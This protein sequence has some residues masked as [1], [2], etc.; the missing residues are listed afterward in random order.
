MAYIG[1]KLSPWFQSDPVNTF[2]KSAALT[3]AKEGREI[4]EKNT[5]VDTGDL[6]AAWQ[7]DVRPKKTASY[8]G[9]GYEASW[10]NKLDYAP[11]VNYGTGLYG[12]EHKKYLIV[13]KKPGGSLHWVDRV[14]GQDVYAK[15]VM[16][17]GSPG[18]YML[19]ISA[20]VVETT[21]DK[22]VKPLLT[23]WA[24]TTERQNPWATIT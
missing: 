20:D 17:P 3:V 7:A 2:T 16:H 19:E 14:T 15:A 9:L 8:I 18:N 12:P 4:A 6:R 1:G 21:W 10:F 13:P 22:I 23:I 11:Y 24:K 5:P